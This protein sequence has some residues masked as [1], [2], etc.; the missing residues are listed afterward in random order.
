MHGAQAGE[1]V[2]N[3]QAVIHSKIMQNDMCVQVQSWLLTK[4]KHRKHTLC[5]TNALVVLLQMGFFND[6]IGPVVLCALIVL[7]LTTIMMMTIFDFFR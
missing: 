1:P 3:D 6:V 7:S 4:P 2:S 5:H